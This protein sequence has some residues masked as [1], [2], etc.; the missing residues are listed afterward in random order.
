LLALHVGQRRQ[1]QKVKLAIT[2]AIRSAKPKTHIEG[3]VVG[4]LVNDEVW[5][6]QGGNADILHSI[7]NVDSASVR[8]GVVCPQRKGRV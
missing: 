4:E 7:V 8:L 5:G 3:V 6:G 1:N 2:V